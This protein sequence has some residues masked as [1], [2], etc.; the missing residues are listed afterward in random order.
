MTYVSKTSLLVVYATIL[1]TYSNLITWLFSK[2][3]SVT[4]QTSLEKSNFLKVK[5]LPMLTLYFLISAKFDLN[6]FSGVDMAKVHVITYE[7]LLEDE[8][9]QVLGFNHVGN[10]SG[11]SMNH[12]PLFTVS[13]F[14][15]MVRWGEVSCIIKSVLSYI[16]TLMRLYIRANSPNLNCLFLI[17]LQN[18][19]FNTFDISLVIDY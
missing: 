13:D 14:A 3:S 16:M 1:Y 9:N 4:S 18:K 17:H 11:A 7:T 8:T 10:V 15:Y 2:T 19:V 12:V 5:C 6:K